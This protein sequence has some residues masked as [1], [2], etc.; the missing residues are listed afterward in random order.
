MPSS[1]ASPLSCRGCLVDVPELKS[2]D[3]YPTDEGKTKKWT[4]ELQSPSPITEDCI[5]SVGVRHIFS[6][7]KG[8]FMSERGGA[9]PSRDR[10]EIR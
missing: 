6:Q 1:L 4:T 2:T 7:E 3:A 9:S 5:G 8:L 10:N